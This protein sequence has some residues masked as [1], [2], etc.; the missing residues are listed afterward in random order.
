[1]QVLYQDLTGD[2]STPDNE[3]N[4]KTHERIKLMLDTQ[5]PDIIIDLRKIIGEKGTKFDVF[6]NEMLDYFNEVI[7]FTSND[8]FS[9][10]YYNDINICILKIL[11][12]YIFTPAVHDQCHTLTLYM[13][14][15][16]FVKDLV[17]IIVE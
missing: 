8:N 10:L 11:K 7:D 4:K 15:A 2:V 9:I 17:Q 14:I 5:D 3:I 13:P 6:W 1:M 16:I 12:G